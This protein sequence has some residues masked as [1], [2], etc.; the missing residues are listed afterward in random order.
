MTRRSIIAG[1][2]SALPARRVSN[3]ELAATL[4]RIALALERLAP[5]PSPSADLNSAA[6]FI[7][8]A[9]ARRLEPVAKVN[10]VDMSLLR[11]IDQ[12]QREHGLEL[13]HI[14]AQS[15]S[16]ASAHPD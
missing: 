4:S 12:S 8:N 3:D 11:G 2:G 10:R 16:G 13:A 14:V 15:G 5:A 7:W 6:A 1:T 9:P